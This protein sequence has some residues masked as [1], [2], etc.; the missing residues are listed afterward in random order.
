MRGLASVDQLQSS[1][2]QGVIGEIEL[3]ARQSRAKFTIHESKRW[4]YPWTW[5]VLEKFMPVKDKRPRV[6]DIGTRK[7]PFPW[8]LPKQGYDVTISEIF[9]IC[10]IKYWFRWRKAEKNLGVQMSKRL[11]DARR[12]H[13]PNESFDVYISTSVLEHISRKDQA[14]AEA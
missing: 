5:K 2:W 4:E 8:W 9:S 13:A 12:L 14:L 1:Y 11:M 3:T 7:S 6:L 10:A